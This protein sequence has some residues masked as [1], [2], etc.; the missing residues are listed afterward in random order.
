[1]LPESM[2]IVYH[3]SAG[4]IDADGCIA[5]SSRAC[6]DIRIVQAEKGLPMLNM[7]KSVHGGVVSKMKEA[8]ERHQAIYVWS[9]Y[10]DDARRLCSNI[11]NYLLVK[12]DQAALALTMPA[13][14]IICNPVIFQNKATDERTEYDSLMKGCR[15]N[16]IDYHQVVYDLKAH[17]I[18][19]YSGFSISKVDMDKDAIRTQ[20][21]AS[22]KRIKEL[23]QEP[24]VPI[25]DDVQL[26][27]AY[28][29][30]F[31]DG[32][33][34]ISVAGKNGHHHTIG[35]KYRPILDL[36]QKKY[37]GSICFKKSSNNYQW[38]LCSGG[39]EFLQDI[40]PHLI[41]KKPQ[42]EI[43]INMQNGEAPAIKERLRELK[44]NYCAHS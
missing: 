25:P 2:D 36:F 30:G 35:Q 16:G 41:L 8:N 3:Y 32:D 14:R 15:E 27:S 28:A 21:Q 34:C 38:C 33:G 7:M 10:G 11:I 31:F 5:F 18:V 12:K 19:E 43:V 39:K 20:K 42:A 1:M 44:G 13:V 17:G 4:L 37:G 23:K 29:A 24:H 6:L 40:Y 26:S 9:V 22:M